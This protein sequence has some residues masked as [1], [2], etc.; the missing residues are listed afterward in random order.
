MYSWFPIY[1][2]FFE[3][4]YLEK[5]QW[6]EISMVRINGVKKIWYE[7]SYKILDNEKKVLK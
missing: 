5:D 2:S 1:F 3:E 7:W 6:I 4:E